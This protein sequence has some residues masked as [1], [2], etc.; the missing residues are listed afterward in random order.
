MSE[1]SPQYEP[2]DEG[3]SQLSL[4]ALK[5]T[6]EKRSLSI[7]EVSERLKIP[8]SH[9][10]TLEAGDIDRLPGLAFARG[11]IRTYGRFL[12]LDTET[13]TLYAFGAGLRVTDLYLLLLFTLSLLFFFKLDQVSRLYLFGLFLIIWIG[14]ILSTIAVRQVFAWARRSGYAVRHIVVVGSGPDASRFVHNLT[15]EHRELGIQIDGFLGP[16]GAVLDSFERL[17]E[18]ED[19]P[20]VLAD[21]VV[22]GGASPRLATTTRKIGVDVDGDNVPE[23]TYRVLDPSGYSRIILFD[24]PGGLQLAGTDSPRSS[25]SRWPWERTAAGE[26]EV[27]APRDQ[28]LRSCHPGGYHHS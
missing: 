22:E 8:A 23:A 21:N 1:Q 10:K 6:R 19:L 5:K 11:Y 7:E 24:G 16:D 2:F 15:L 17:G 3:S 14:I 20:A 26:D 12:G 18:V 27:P 25:G 13:G 4:L 9:L 28:E